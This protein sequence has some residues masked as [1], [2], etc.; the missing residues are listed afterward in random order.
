MC[1]CG[2]GC[3]FEGERE[4]ERERTLRE[5]DLNSPTREGRSP[6]IRTKKVSTNGGQ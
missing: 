5:M 2:G 3:A 6:K 4:R 1:V